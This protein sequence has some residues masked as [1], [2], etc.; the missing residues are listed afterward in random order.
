M[1]RRQFLKRSALVSAALPFFSFACSDDLEQPLPEYRYAG[2]LGPVT[3]FSHGV[4]SGDPLADGI[5][6][7]T[8]ITPRDLG[9]V[10]VFW[11]IARDKDFEDR[12]GAD[13]AVAAQ[14]HDW[15]VKIDV[16]GLEP[17]QEYFYRFFALGRMS[18]IG[19]TRTLP[20]GAVD[21]LSLAVVSCSNMPRG[22]FQVYRE[23][24]RR[25]DLFGVLH[26]GDYIYEYGGTQASVR[27]RAPQPPWEITTLHDYRTRYAQYRSD[28]DLQAVH[29][30]HPFITVWDD[31]ETANNS[32]KDGADNHQEST[33]GPWEKR[34]EA[35][36]RAYF[37]WLPIRET[38]IG[39]VWRKFQFGN[40]VEL[41]MLDTRLWGR[42]EIPPFGLNGE[43]ANED[44]Q[45]LGED[46]ETWL[47][48]SLVESQATWKLIGQQ[49]V[50][51][52]FKLSSNPDV[53]VNGDQWD[54]YA[55]ARKRL[56]DAISE[57]SV[58][59]IVVVTGDIHS[60][61]ANEL[62]YNSNDADLY[63]PETGQGILGVE[64]VTPAV[65]SRGAAELAGSLR[66]L[67]FARNPHIKYLE[68]TKNGYINVV[69]QADRMQGH[70]WHLDDIENYD[71]PIQNVASFEVR[72]GDPRLRRLDE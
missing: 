17:G 22:F 56:F 8:R 7:W 51:A 32:W 58:K 72:K 53:F 5:I 26:L 42:D 63:N 12:V 28:R 16:S 44:R 55:Q 4:A 27:E 14:V 9:P 36:I 52:Q 23:L 70:F 46:Q 18:H 71:S 69:F 15:T 34:K 19:R 43:V 38:E 57:N 65:S 33:E 11:E 41:H 60:S 13:W 39:R 48:E 54:G 24:A 40:L 62:T 31:H 59:D 64:F 29:Q 35:G 30:R 47:H 1:D 2:A 10:E 50:M 6:I 37:E 3:T 67:V 21:E 25:D 66:D 68:A 61:W 49:V 20:T 45:L